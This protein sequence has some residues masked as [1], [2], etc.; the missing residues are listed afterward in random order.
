MKIFRKTRT[1]GG[2]WKINFELLAGNFEKMLKFG[3]NF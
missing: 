3:E 1:L 2:F